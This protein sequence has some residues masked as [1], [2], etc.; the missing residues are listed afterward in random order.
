MPSFDIVSEIDQQEVDN[1]LNQARK[2]IATRFDFKNAG[3]EFELEG[4]KLTL[5]ALDGL[6]ARALLEIVLARLA[7]RNVPLQ[8]IERG[9]MEISSTGHAR[10]VLT[11]KQGIDHPTAK[12]IM[13]AIRDSKIKVTCQSQEEK[14][15]VQGKSR[16]DLQAVIQLVRAGDFGPALS[17]NNF[18]D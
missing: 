10:Q 3:A 2:E 6:K 11:L 12:K 9:D 18:R 15:R 1:A 13:Q 16:D 17:F 14:I 8:N 5:R 7:R 4:A